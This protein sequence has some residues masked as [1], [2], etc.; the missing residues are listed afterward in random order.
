MPASSKKKPYS[1]DELN[2]MNCD[3]LKLICKTEGLSY[4]KKVKA[5]LIESILGVQKSG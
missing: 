1:A 5:Q 2:L 4:A 3:A